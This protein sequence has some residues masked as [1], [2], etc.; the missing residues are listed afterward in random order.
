MARQRSGMGRWWNDGT[1]SIVGNAKIERSHSS[2]HPRREFG[3]RQFERPD[4][5][6]T[7]HCS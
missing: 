4:G 6:T 1:D 2:P 5:E 7:S 3:S